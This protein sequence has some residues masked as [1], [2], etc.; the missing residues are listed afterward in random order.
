MTKEAIWCHGWH[1]FGKPNGFVDFFLKLID[2]LLR[3]I[4]GKQVS[5]YQEFL[6]TRNRVFRLPCLC[7]TSTT[8]AWKTPAKLS[9]S[10][11]S[12]SEVAPSPH[13]PTETTG[14]PA[15]LAAI[16]RPTAC[17]ICVPITI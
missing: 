7:T 13:T 9:A 11:K 15:I 17:N 3:T 5:P 8:R 14:S 1:C 2:G 16:A 10:L 4:F 6:E 12:P